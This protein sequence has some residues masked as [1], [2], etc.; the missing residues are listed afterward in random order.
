MTTPLD[1][2]LREAALAWCEQLRQRW[3]DHVPAIEVR[4]FP[5]RGQ[6][7]F[8][9]GQQGIFKPQVMGDG[10]LSIRTSLHGP[11]QDEVLDGGGTV[12]YDY[13]PRRGENDGLKRL[14]K[15]G[16]PLIYLVQ[17]IRSQARST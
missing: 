2:Q 5:F 6:A 3:G 17:V 10:P 15:D 4:R 11:Y 13:S 9:Y 14:A 12:R 8:L 7:V 16:T 1:F